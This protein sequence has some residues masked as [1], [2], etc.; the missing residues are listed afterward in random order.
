MGHVIHIG[1]RGG[2][3]TAF[4]SITIIADN[5]DPDKASNR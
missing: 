3:Q 2:N 1:Q 5:G 4:H